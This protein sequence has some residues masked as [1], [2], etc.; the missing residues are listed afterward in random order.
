[1]LFVVC[2]NDA[3]FRAAVFSAYHRYLWNRS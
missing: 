3:S 1:M 2:V